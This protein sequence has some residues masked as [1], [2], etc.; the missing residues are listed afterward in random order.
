MKNYYYLLVIFAIAGCRDNTSEIKT[1]LDEYNQ[2][3][4]RL[5][6]A[7]SQA[8]WKTNTEIRDGDTL[9]AY[10]SRVADEALTEFTGSVGNI[11]NAKKF[12]KEKDRL[13]PLQV[14]QLEAILFNA[15]SDPQTVAPLVKE[16]IKASIAQTEKLFGFAYE[17]DGKPVTTNDLDE[18]LRDEHQL[19]KRLDAWEASKEVGKELK[20]GLINL[21]RLRNETVQALDYH[22]Y[23]SYQ[24]SD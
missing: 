3:Y 22:D 13:E 8:S 5:Y 20:D 17:L 2:T 11:E 1:F 6:Y 21:R 18:I 16:K 14:R 10:H 7:S 12:L 24:V 4:T 23:F 9:N 15:G 19:H